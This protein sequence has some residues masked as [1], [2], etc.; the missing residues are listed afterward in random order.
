MRSGTAMLAAPAKAA[1]DRHTLAP[2]RLENDESGRLVA[3][4]LRGKGSSDLVSF[5]NAEVLIDLEMN[6]LIEAGSLVRILH[7]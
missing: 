7:L 4:P 5:A 2:A 6:T 1:K 3:I